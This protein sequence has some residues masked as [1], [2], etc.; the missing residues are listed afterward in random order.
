MPAF[1]LALL[2]PW[3][4]RAILNKKMKRISLKSLRPRTGGVAPSGD[5]PWGHRSIYFQDPDGNFLNFY[6]IIQE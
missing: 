4:Q 6:S 5:L 3:P 1:M 2:L